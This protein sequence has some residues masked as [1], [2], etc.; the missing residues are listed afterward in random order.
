[1]E[2]VVTFH[3]KESIK[4]EENIYTTELVIVLPFD[5]DDDEI[6]EA[7]RTAKRIKAFYMGSEKM[8]VVDMKALMQ[9]A[10]AAGIE[11]LD[12]EGAFEGKPI[13]PATKKQM[14]YIKGLLRQAEKMGVKVDLPDLNGLDKVR[15][16][17]LID[18][19]R[20]AVRE[21]KADKGARG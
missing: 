6:S 7:V 9:K 12:E 11:F 15:A 2:R 18:S 8:P 13:E 5:A 14:G 19:L 1:M 20:A 17:Q 21:A 4:V 16:S 3:A 10:E